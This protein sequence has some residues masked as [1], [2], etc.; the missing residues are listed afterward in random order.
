MT[1][2][3]SEI[4]DDVTGK[5]EVGAKTETTNRPTHRVYAVKKT[6]GDKSHWT[7]IGA[8]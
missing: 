5:G 7:E 4:T 1:H 6:S 3:A 2:N 8:R